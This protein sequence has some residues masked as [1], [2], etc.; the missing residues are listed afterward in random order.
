MTILYVWYGT[1]PYTRKIQPALIGPPSQRK[2]DPRP[3]NLRGRPITAPSAAFFFFF[4]IHRGG[5][6]SLVLSGL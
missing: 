5:A 3:P 6:Q 2:Y 1:I 4:V